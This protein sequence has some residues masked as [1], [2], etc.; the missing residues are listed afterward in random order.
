MSAAYK[1]PDC[2]TTKIMLM[3]MDVAPHP[4]GVIMAAAHAKKVAAKHAGIISD[5]MVFNWLTANETDGNPT[6]D[7]Q[8]AEF[9]RLT[10]D[11]IFAQGDDGAGLIW[12]YNCCDGDIDSL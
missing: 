9:I 3:A 12:D 11:E 5:L 4:C 2:L 10:Q 8:T 6:K 1:I 7:Q